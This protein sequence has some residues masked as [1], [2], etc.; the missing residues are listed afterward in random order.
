MARKQHHQKRRNGK[1]GPRQDPSYNSKHPMYPTYQPM[2]YYGLIK[3]LEE[4]KKGEAP[5]HE[6]PL[7]PPKPPSATPGE[8]NGWMDTVANIGQ[9]AMAAKGVYDFL[10]TGNVGA[11]LF[12][13]RRGVQVAR[14]AFPRI[15]V[16]PVGPRVVGGLA[17]EGAE[18]AGAIEGVVGAGLVAGLP[19]GL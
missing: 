13:A 19:F 18:I 16:V 3:N 11:G 5:A 17:A 2:N 15:P 8:G 10:T 4:D 1:R 12:G 9:A 7:E 6:K 14:R